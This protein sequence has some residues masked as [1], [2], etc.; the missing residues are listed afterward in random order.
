MVTLPEKI[1]QIE[2]VQTRF[3]ERLRWL[4]DAAYT[5]RLSRLELPTLE[6]RRLQLDLIFCYTVVFGLTSLTTS[7]Y[8]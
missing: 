8:F 6:L 7:G 4:H 3:T 5:E 2:I 1:S